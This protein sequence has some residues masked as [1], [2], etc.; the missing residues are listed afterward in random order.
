MASNLETALALF[1]RQ[2]GVVEGPSDW[3]AIEQERVDAFADA[4]DDHQFIH[5]D[6]QRAKATPFGGTIAHGFLTLSLLPYLQTQIPSSEPGLLQGLAMAINYGLD[7][8]R[9]PTPVPVGRRVRATRELLSVEVKAANA[10]QTSQRISI[11]LEGSE[12]P[13]CVAEALTRWFYL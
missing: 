9:F 1:Q 11:E 5:V 6:P 3:I 4:T 8:V 7:K 12:K 10:L 2:I 13:A